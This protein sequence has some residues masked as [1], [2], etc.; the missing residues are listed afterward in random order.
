LIEVDV[1]AGPRFEQLPDAHDLA[2]QTINSVVGIAQIDAAVVGCV[3][4]AFSPN[5]HG[6]GKD[7]GR[8]ARF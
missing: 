7:G 5:R 8:I 3:F 6:Y 1:I 2:H 4:A